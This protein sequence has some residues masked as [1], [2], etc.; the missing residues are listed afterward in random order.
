MKFGYEISTDSGS[1][2]LHITDLAQP[3]VTRRRGEQAFQKLQPLL[4]EAPIE[5][6]L[7]LADMLS[8]SFLDGLVSKLINS[9]SVDVVTFVSDDESTIR[10]LDRISEIRSARLVSAQ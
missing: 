3:C 8:M 1:E 9:E 5:V 6:D 2:T 4:G 10:K 7:N